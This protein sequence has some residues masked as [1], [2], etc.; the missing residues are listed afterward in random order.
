MKCSINVFIVHVRTL[1]SS[2]THTSKVIN[3]KCFMWLSVVLVIK[4]RNCM[5][6]K[7]QN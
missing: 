2:S 1:K 4:V 7:L 3:G 5:L 6:L